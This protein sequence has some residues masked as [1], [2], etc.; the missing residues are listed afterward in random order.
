MRLNA[1]P[2]KFS[3]QLTLKVELITTTILH[4][5]RY[6]QASQRY[7]NQPQNNTQQ[8]RFNH[9]AF[10]SMTYKPRRSNKFYI[11]FLLG[12]Y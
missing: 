5:S 9:A 10:P 12:L 3:M 1:G 6:K 4:V 11:L 7:R 8:Q 2:Q